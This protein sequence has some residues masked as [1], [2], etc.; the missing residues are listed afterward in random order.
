MLKEIERREWSKAKQTAT[1]C[2]N[3]RRT[4]WSL[5]ENLSAVD[6]PQKSLENRIKLLSNIERLS[7]RIRDPP[8]QSQPWFSVANFPPIPNIF[9]PLRLSRSPSISTWRILTSPSYLLRPPFKPSSLSRMDKIT[10][11]IKQLKY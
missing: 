7:V 3:Y 9:G 2:V 10:F 6:R 8:G 5:I 11:T 1:D 4:H